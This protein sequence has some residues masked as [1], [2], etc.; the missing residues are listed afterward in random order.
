LAAAISSILLTA[1]G[2][3]LPNRLRS[4]DITLLENHHVRNHRHPAP[5]SPLRAAGFVAPGRD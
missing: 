1:S 4:I 2:L 3:P 5:A